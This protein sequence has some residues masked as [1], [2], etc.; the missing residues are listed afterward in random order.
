MITTHS[1]VVASLRARLASH[2]YA[3]AL[4]EARSALAEGFD[5]SDVLILAAT[6]GQLGDG[7]D[8]SLGEIRSWLEQ[9][10]AADPRNAEAHIELGHFLDAVMDEPQA[11][12]YAFDTALAASVD[13]LDATLDG[14]VSSVDARDVQRNA[15]LRALLDRAENQVSAVR[16]SLGQ[17]HSDLT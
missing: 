1:A 12:V 6:A 4:K 13:R 8:C 5:S 3:E 15:R 17:S 2:Q 9:A 10:A 16:S 14:I 7:E 11:A